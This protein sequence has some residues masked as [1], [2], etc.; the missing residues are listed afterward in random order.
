MPKTVVSSIDNL[1]GAGGLIQTSPSNWTLYNSGISIRLLGGA[2]PHDQLLGV[3]G[4]IVSQYLFWGVLASV[5]SISLPLRPLTSNLTSLGTN[6]SGT[7]VLRT[8][9]V[10][11]GAYSGV[12]KV[13]YR[14]TSTGALEW[15]LSFVPN[16]SAQYSVGLAWWNVTDGFTLSDQSRTFH[17][18][19]GAANFTLS[20]NDVSSSFGISSGVSLRQLSISI[21]IGFV[22]AGSSVVIDP[23]VSSDV[24]V[25]GTA[26]TFQRHV[27][28]DSTSR[29]YWVFYDN[30]GCTNYRYSHD[31]VQWSNASTIP[32]WGCGGPQKFWTT[33]VY[34]IG[35]NVI[36]A[37]GQESS[38][39]V[40]GNNTGIFGNVVYYQTGTVSGNSIV[41]SSSA[42][43]NGYQ[44]AGVCS[45]TTQYCS[46]DVGMRNVNVAW[47]VAGTTAYTALVYSWFDLTQTTYCQGNPAPGTDYYGNGTT[48]LEYR[49]VIVQLST[50][51]GCSSNY[52][53]A[54]AYALEGI[55]NAVLVPAD[56]AGGIRVLYNIPSGNVKSLWTNGI[57]TG[58]VETVATNVVL[59]SAA[60]DSSYGIHA[61]LFNGNRNAWYAY[62]PASGPSWTVSSGLF[63]TAISSPSLTIDYTTNDV[64]AL[65]INGSGIDLKR[66]PLS[67]QWADQSFTLPVAGL[68]NASYL[69]SNILSAGGTNSSQIEL[70]WTQG[71]GSGPYSV[72][73]ASVPI[74]TVWSPYSFPTD[75]WDGN[76]VVPYGQYFSS[77]GESV[78]PSSGMLAVEQTD[79]KVP[80]RGLDLSI[81]RVYTEPY[82]FPNGAISIYESYPWAP[83]GYG[84]QFNFPWFLNTSQPIQVHLWDGQ[85]YRIPSSFWA[86]TSSTFENHQG[87]DFRMVR[88]S[89][90]IFMYS[91]SGTVYK[92]DPGHLNRLTKYFDP[93][94]NNLTLAYYS[95]TNQ[96]SNITDT[97]GRSFQFCY[98]SGLMSTIDQASGSCGHET[99]FVRRIR[100]T[101]SGSDLT[102]MTDPIGRVTSYQYQGVNDPVIGP[103]ILSRI[104]Y[105]TRWYTTYTYKQYA[106][107]TQATTYG[108]SQQ[109]VS[110]S[111]GTPVRQFTYS[112]NRGF[113]GAQVSASSVQ[114]FNGTYTGG[115]WQLQLASYNNYSFSFSGVE[116]N[117]SSASHSLIRGDQQVFGVNGKITKETLLVTDGV[118]SVGSY[119]NYYQYDLWGNLIYTRKSINPSQNWYH[120]SFSSYYNDAMPQGFY[121]LRDTF[122]SRNY[123]SPDDP[124]NI[125]NG[126]WAVKNGVY[127]GTWTTGPDENT[128][129]WGDIGKGDVSLQA[130]LYINSV[131]LGDPNG[132]NRTGVFV[133]Y[134]GYNDY[135]WALVVHT[136]PGGGPYLELVDDPASVTNWWSTPN[137]LGNYQPSARSACGWSSALIQT[138][139]WYTFNMTVHGLSATG[140]IDIPGQPRCT[141]SGMF[142]QSSLAVN[143]TGF[144]MYPGSSSTLF[145]NVTVATVDPYV[146]AASFSNSFYQNG[147]PALT[148]HGAPAGTAELQ[149][150]TG[151]TP[152]ESYYNYN[153]SGSLIL[154]KQLYNN[155]G[156]LQWMTTSRTYD[157]FGNL[158]TLTDARGNVTRY[159]YSSKY[160]FGYLTSQN[161]TLMPGS[162][163]VSTRYSYNFT[164]G[165]LLS[166]V[167]PNGYNTTYQ[168]DLLGRLKRVVYPTG[169]YEN[170]TYNDSARFVDIANENGWKTRQIYDG[171]GRLSATDRF[172]GI[173]SY[174]NNTS[175]YDL[176]DKPVTQRDAMGNVTTYQYDALER[177]TQITEP[178]GNYTRVFYNDTASWI[179]FQNENG[180]Y[181]CDISDRLGRLLFVL[182]SAS[183][184]CV[185]GSLTLYLYDEVSN[186]VRVSNPN[187]TDLYYHDS[188]NRLTTRM[189]LDHTIE[190]YTYDKNGNT[191]TKTDRKGIQTNYQ[192]DSLNRVTT[193]TYHGA[194]ITQE[195]YTYDADGNLLQLQ[196][197]NATLTYTYDRRNRV[198]CEI[199][200]VNGADPTQVTGPCGSGGGGGSVA[201]GTLITMADGSSLPV[202]NLQPGMEV[203]SYNV[204]TG[205]F[206]I[207]KITRMVTVNTNDMLVIRT[208]D[209][210]P[211]RTDNATIQNLWVKQ[212]DGNVGWLSVTRLRVG[213]SLYLAQAHQWTL[214]TSIKDTPGNFVMYDIYNTAPGDYLAN[215]YLDP[216]K[217]PT[218][219]PLVPGGMYPDGY[220]FQYYYVGENLIQITYN[221]YMT[222]VYGYDGLGRVTSL[223]F[224]T[225]SPTTFTYFP[226][227]QVRGIRYGNGLVE[228]Y[229]Y[230]K[231]SRVLQNKLTNS[232]TVVLLLNYAYYKTGTVASVNGQSTTTS[233]SPINLSESYKY[234]SLGRLTNTTVTAGTTTTLSW[235]EYDMLGNRLWQGLNSSATGYRWL[236]T[237][238][239]YNSTNNE[240]LSST[241]SSATASY[242]YNANGNLIAQNVTTTH[243]THWTYSWDVSGSL[244]NAANYST[245]QGYYAYDGL[246]RRVESKENAN[247]LYYGYLGTE[248]L[249]DLGT[250]GPENNYVYANGLR[251]ARV[252]NAQGSNPTI[253]YYHTDALGSTR[254]V[255]STTK[256]ILFSDSYQPFG[257]DNSASG[258]ETYKFTGKPYS[259][260][261]GLYYDYARWYDPSI[262]RFISADRVAGYRR[263]PQSLNPYVYVENS[264]TNSVDPSGLDCL[265]SL[266]D[267]GSCAGSFV[268][269]NTVGAAVNSYNW[270][271]GAS[272]SDRWAF[273]TGVA[274]AVGIGVVIG[275]S[276]VFA[277]CAGLAL[278]GIGLLT[279]AAGSV[280]AADAY[281][282][283]GGQ[284]EGG[285][286][287]SL[288][289]GGIGGGL[290]FGAGGLGADLLRGGEDALVTGEIPDGVRATFED[291]GEACLTQDFNGFQYGS[292]PEYPSRYV[293][294]TRFA[295]SED[296]IRGLRLPEYN[297]A[298]YV[299]TITIPK[300]SYVGIGQVR[301]GT[302]IQVWVPNLEQILGGPWVPL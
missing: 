32:V 236:L 289:W 258:S 101:Q 257:Q 112:Y 136:W 290:G 225:A 242:R 76:G 93:L 148:I 178:D 163:L 102:N 250:G 3:G 266:S 130:N 28:F 288:F 243:S 49:N 125:F 171:L 20:W 89:T 16:T 86:G 152:I 190:S 208:A 7:F 120:E 2:L 116:W 227:D 231:D 202:Q 100:Y 62:R 87:E 239:A 196:S 230:D 291:C 88:N 170:Y 105:A 220:S 233:G 256:S 161:A 301:G 264:P 75:P 155:S 94:G 58:S 297:T 104:T 229:T 183:S 143:G 47:G 79:L 60:S 238:Y 115:A 234:D 217:G 106:L 19:Y 9:Q 185:Q 118:R 268:Y 30:N 22:N 200:L 262:G 179:R 158:A 198:L 302:A 5:G 150:G 149:N 232:G 21:N 122:S 247:Y 228:N 213:D 269:D 25:L 111:S 165:A 260:A 73:F 77:L 78:S 35:R 251:I 141:V 245:V 191:V 255:T 187:L 275:A 63:P 278:L 226:N 197:Q 59:S 174:S 121:A 127:N 71:S 82:A 292:S 41:W 135:K 110:T 17:E 119:T 244:L 221:D 193:I 70:V 241:S 295:T 6:S 175:T 29:N 252:N 248:T 209:G 160:Q 134:A 283:A 40:S 172:R 67:Q 281:R 146:A 14:A 145:G 261:T 162:S 153:A 45:T 27:F 48:V 159:G 92:F 8:M 240:L 54:S 279:G 18:N 109:L 13:V 265:S 98:A 80:G 280:W 85:G 168:Y 300:G 53:V 192:Y 37:H 214:V 57:Q 188:L 181:K 117:V 129:S 144:G 69:G 164:T 154:A 284:S 126:A 132:F 298:S 235:Y 166:T 157:R 249:A 66:K 204:T 46:Y 189:H 138:R 15:D 72:M 34:N 223:Q 108:V 286:K 36:V 285:L 273:W 65:A 51:A 210:Q 123:T 272:D 195:Q 167:D 270:Y 128:F 267:F 299:R 31:G 24:G 246:G 194:I 182:E 39:L 203:V 282:F 97:V 294:S 237:N 61:V 186:L 81:T 12:F 224:S 23:T 219:G 212:A 259:A 276:C 124:W 68:T 114:A 274:V 107:G 113:G 137:W 74:Q 218:R 173:A 177:P 293:T 96:I 206:A 4:T 26:Y 287:A 90:G 91:K 205:F 147:N 222:A 296:A 199:Y 207:S 99:G 169:D 216:I 133:H 277:A 95:S 38:G 83:L 254:L 211:L 103:W 10:S 215:G 180:N 50:S 64:Y 176:Q 131:N 1:I 263:D 184:N 42:Q 44:P 140:W 142:S 33:A 271:Q 151:S 11:S 56:S 55:E 253:V 201:A 84:W 156:N 52:G 43:S 139:V